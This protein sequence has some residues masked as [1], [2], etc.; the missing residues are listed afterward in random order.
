[1]EWILERDRAPTKSDG[2]M[3]NKNKVQV[4][5]LTP[6]GAVERRNYYVASATGGFDDYDLR[7]VKAWRPLPTDI[8]AEPYPTRRNRF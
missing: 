1:M 4:E 7:P 2:P 6:S 5:I 3:A 8:P